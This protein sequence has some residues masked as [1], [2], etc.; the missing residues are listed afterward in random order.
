MRLTCI[1][2]LKSNYPCQ[3]FFI[4]GRERK[5]AGSEAPGNF[6]EKCLC[7]LRKHP[8]DIERELKKDT[9]VLLL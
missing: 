4:R 9:C 6:L 8:F 3:H 5:W 1:V 7:I 2:T